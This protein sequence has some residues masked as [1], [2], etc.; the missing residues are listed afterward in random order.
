MSELKISVGGDVEKAA[1]ERFVEAWHRAEHG[2][3]GQTDGDRECQ[4]NPRKRGHHRRQDLPRRREPAVTASHGIAAGGR[5]LPPA[6]AAA[7]ADSRSMARLSKASLR[8]TT[9]ASG[10]VA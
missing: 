2:D 9:S 7:E 8:V 4:N 5:L 1:S 3:R 10:P 6:L